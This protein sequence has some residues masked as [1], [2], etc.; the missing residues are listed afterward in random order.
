[1]KKKI[2]RRDCWE[3]LLLILLTNSHVQVEI[4]TMHAAAYL[5]G[6]SA[7]LGGNS[8]K[9]RLIVLLGCLPG[10]GQ[11]R[12]WSNG[13]IPHLL[14][15]HTYIIFALGGEGLAQVL[16][17]RFTQFCWMARRRKM[18]IQPANTFRQVWLDYLPPPIWRRRMTPVQIFAEQF[19]TGSLTGKA[20]RTEDEQTG[21]IWSGIAAIDIHLFW[22]AN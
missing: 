17:F 13:L 5:G 22:E 8:W 21:Q 14:I 15:L 3:S 4:T 18:Y 12:S 9:Q 11:G 1:M 10:M 19:W 7:Y 20:C 16:G 6:N 2:T